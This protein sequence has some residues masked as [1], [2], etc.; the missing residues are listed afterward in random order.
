MDTATCATTRAERR[1][2]GLAFAQP[3]AAVAQVGA[4][5]GAGGFRVVVTDGAQNAFMFGMHFLQV[6]EPSFGCSLRGVEARARYH[7]GA[8]IT[9]QDG[10]MTV[11]GG[12]GHLHVKGKV[13]RHGIAVLSQGRLKLVQGRLHLDQLR[14]GAPQGGQ[15][16][17]LGL[18]A[19]AQF[20]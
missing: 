16:G 6:I 7:H 8:Q 13:R 17:G 9:Q 18:Q 10:K 5:G 14:F 20:Q 3:L 4:H 12:A 1:G 2:L 19:D 15:A 11:M